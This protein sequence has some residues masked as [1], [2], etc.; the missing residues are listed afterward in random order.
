MIRNTSQRCSQCGVIVKKDLSTRWHDCPICGCHLHRDYNA[1][2]NILAL[3]LQS[4]GIQSL[5]AHVL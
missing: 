3:G 4:L 1:S 2:K 5:E